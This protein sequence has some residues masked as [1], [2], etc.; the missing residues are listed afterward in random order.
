MLGQTTLFPPSKDLPL[1]QRVQIEIIT[2]RQARHALE[3]YHYLH[4][5]RVGRQINYAVIIDGIVDGI[6]TYAYPMMSSPLLGI[7]SDELVEFARLY[8]HKNIPHTAT[9]AIGKSIKRI[10][11]DWKIKFPD[12][13]SLRLI[14]SWS[15]T[16]HHKGTIYKA[17]NFQWIKKTEGGGAGNTS[18]SKR[19]VRK[20]YVDYN[21]QK[22]CWI[23]WL[24]KK[25][26]TPLLR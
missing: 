11:A 19:G 12:A 25:S 2:L 4:R 8:L 22:D 26:T 5:T 24:D 17:S 10:A 15:D 6:I 18:N 3:T 23:Y 7:P 16:T 9:C 14:V 1:R 20:P 21:H 13:K